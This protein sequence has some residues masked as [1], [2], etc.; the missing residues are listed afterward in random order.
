MRSFALYL[1]FLQKHLTYFFN[2]G[3]SE[4]RYL[5]KE[6]N[7]MKRLLFMNPITYSISKGCKWITGTFYSS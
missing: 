7:N 5:R 1:T 2:Q 4:F 3:S 6:G